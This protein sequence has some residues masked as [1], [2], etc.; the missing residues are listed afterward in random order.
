MKSLQA[1]HFPL[2]HE[3]QAVLFSGSFKSGRQPGAVRHMQRV[4][5]WVSSNLYL[6]TA[7]VGAILKDLNLREYECPSHCNLLHHLKTY[8]TGIKCLFHV[9]ATHNMANYSQEA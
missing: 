9:P 6:S 4:V 3:R 2:L 1:G 5:T 8:C 7:L